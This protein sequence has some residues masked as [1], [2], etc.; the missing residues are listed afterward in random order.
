[1]KRDISRR[2]FL[3]SSIAAGAALAGTRLAFSDTVD[4]SVISDQ[5]K[6][7][8]NAKGLP[9]T[10][11]GRTGVVIPRIAIGLGSRFLTIK[12][13]EEA[14]EMCNYA[15]DNGLYYWDTAHTYVNTETGAVSE[16]R[17]GHIV[18]DRRKE[19]FLSTKI[20]ARDTDEAKKQI[21]LSLKRLQTDHL[22]MMKIHAVETMDEVRNLTKPGGVI[23]LFLKMKQEG[24]TRFI[25][26]SGH[27]NAE[28]LKAMVETD[29]FD[30]MLFAMNHYDAGKNDRQ[31]MVIPAA[32][33]LGMGVMLMK[34][35]RPKET[36]QGLDPSELVRF[37][38]SL[39]GPNGIAVGMDSKKVV[40]ANLNILRNF[41][42]MTQD[43]RLKYAMVLSP[44]F[45]HE[46]L[47]WMNNG[48]HDGHWA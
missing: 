23:D 30:S 36:I 11:L 35:I 28:A 18:K 20:A 41:R 1:M 7:P 14:I 38:L 16:E 32:R 40:D 3:K 34:T 6:N 48:Y 10:T 17:L 24:V 9:T 45:R 19:I 5:A 22:D 47:A 8:Y 12:T 37:A 21:E 13:L 44:Y 26:F 4:P 2:R 42:P 15:L 25:G 33:K 46:N 43:E 27:S 29:R 39:E 31:G